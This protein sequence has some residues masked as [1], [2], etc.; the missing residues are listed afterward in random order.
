M[1]CE[2][3]SWRISAN[4]NSKQAPK[5][6][7]NQHLFKFVCQNWQAQRFYVDSLAMLAVNRYSCSKY[8]PAK[9]RFP[10]LEKYIFYSWGKIKNQNIAV[11]MSYDWL[12]WRQMFEQRALE[13]SLTNFLGFLTL[14]RFKSHFSPAMASSSSNNSSAN[15][16]GGHN[17]LNRLSLKSAGK[18]NQESMSHSQ[19]N[20]GWINGKAENLGEPKFKGKTRKNIK[21]KNTHLIRKSALTHARKKLN[22]TC[23]NWN[24]AGK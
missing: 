10:A 14:E 13:W 17:P 3:H 9:Q 23:R 22:K 7:T 8:N 19:P 21:V 4:L 1:G 20:G 5:N 18:R 24:V 12:K 11:K 6:G 2:I 15:N 16:H